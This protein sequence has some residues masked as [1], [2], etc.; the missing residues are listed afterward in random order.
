MGPGCLCSGSASPRASVPPLEHGTPSP[1]AHP[2]RPGL[3]THRPP[4]AQLRRPHTD[5]L[6]GPREIGW[7][8]PRSPGM[9]R[10]DKQAEWPVT[11]ACCHKPSRV[12]VLCYSTSWR[13]T[14]LL[15]STATLSLQPQV[16]TSK[17]PEGEGQSCLLFVE[18]LRLHDPNPFLRAE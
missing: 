15:T 12:K 17:S 3:Q 11:K 16:T 18:H 2:L 1:R 6:S 8:G 9:P 4:Q 7:P 5:G 13:C 10:L 14:R